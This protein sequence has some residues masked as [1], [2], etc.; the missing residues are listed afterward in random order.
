MSNLPL[1]AA[2]FHLSYRLGVVDQKTIVDW[3]TE[4]LGNFLSPPEVLVEVTFMKE[5]HPADLL[6]ALKKLS[7]EVEPI[8]V[9]PNVM[10]R[11]HKVLLEKPVL[12]NHFTRT[13]YQIASEHD[14]NLPEEYAPIY[15]FDD[16]LAL[17]ENGTYGRVEEI[18]QEVVEFT[19]SF[20]KR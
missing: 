3:A 14:F 2:E 16:E 17:A 9:F 6:G 13:L 8:A 19:A 10:A 5:S 7:G 11:A 15:G 4:S 20:H 18:Y 12:L 1:Q